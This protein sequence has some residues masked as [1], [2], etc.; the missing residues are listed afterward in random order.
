MIQTAE[1]YEFVHRALCLFEQTLDNKKSISND[2]DLDDCGTDK[3]NLAF[4]KIYFLLRPRMC[5]SS[6][7]GKQSPQIYFSI[8]ERMRERRE[9]ERERMRECVWEQKS[10][11]PDSSFWWATGS[12]NKLPFLNCH[13]ESL[14]INISH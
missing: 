13:D 4:A 1:Q 10:L 6:A 9:K 8:G 11:S 12:L 5:V 2:W 7:W 3:S 14:T